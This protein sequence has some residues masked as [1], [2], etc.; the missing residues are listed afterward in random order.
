MIDTGA[1]HIIEVLRE[2]GHVALLAG[3][4]VRDLVMRV[5]PRDWDIATDADPQAVMRYF[6]RTAPVGVKFGIVLVLLEQGRYEVARF[7]RDGP[8]TDGR[9][10]SQVAWVEAEEDARRRDFTVN[11][12]FYDPAEGRVIDHVGGIADVER[13]LVRAIGDPHQR[14]EE[15]HLRMVRAARFAA[16]LGFE[17]DAA[18]RQAIVDVAPEIRSTS[19]ERIRDELTAILTHT[20]ASR[21]VQLLLDL[22]LMVQILPEVAAMDGV[23][24]SPEHHPE[25]DVWTHVKLMLDRLTDP[26]PTLAWGI[27]LHDVGKPVTRTI[28][29]RIRFHDHDRRG[30]EMVDAIA[31]RLRFSREETERIRD[32]T[33]HHMRLRHVREM[34]PSKLKRFLREPYFAELLELHRVD[35]LASHGK[36]DLYEFCQ[37]QLAQSGPTELRPLRLI[38]GDDLIALGFAPGPLFAEILSHLEDDQLEGR[39]TTREEAVERVQKLY[40]RDG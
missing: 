11:G 3:G 12:M 6:P 21:G 17:L 23:P 25:G 32:L 27:L 30:A 37:Q 22:G 31:Q 19:G 10:P 26:T 9:H 5:P 38:T 24:Q 28:S 36:L 20:S 29:D 39:I 33:A 40:G 15:D 16:R 2:R 4:C 13:G 1:L 18:T 35:C 34:R 8:Y 14:L 7:R